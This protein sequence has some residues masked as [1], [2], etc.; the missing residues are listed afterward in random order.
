MR[1]F[2]AVR[3]GVF[4]LLVLAALTASCASMHAAPPTR[5]QCLD[6]LAS[7]ADVEGIDELRKDTQHRSHHQVARREAPA[8]KIGLVA[9]RPGQTVEALTRKLDRP[10]A[11]QFRPLLVGL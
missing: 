10:R 6:E 7:A 5:Q 3:S 8:I 2:C 9:Q 4:T 11:A 1:A